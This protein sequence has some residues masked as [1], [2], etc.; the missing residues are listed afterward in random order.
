MNR[1][2]E[3]PATTPRVSFTRIQPPAESCTSAG[4][5]VISCACRA[6]LAAPASPA[7]PPEWTLGRA[8]PCQVG[9]RRALQA[10]AAAVASV[11]S[12]A[13]TM[14]A[15]M[16]SGRASQPTWGPMRPLRRMRS[17]ACA[18][19]AASQ[20]GTSC[21]GSATR[22]A[23]SPSRMRW[24]RSRPKARCVNW[25]RVEAASRARTA[26]SRSVDS[27]AT[28]AGPACRTRSEQT[29][30]VITVPMAIRSWRMKPAHITT[31]LAHSVSKAS[32]KFAGTLHCRSIAVN[33]PSAPVPLTTRSYASSR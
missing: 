25:A 30:S 18:R 22:P 28:M 4:G 33:A 16:P 13:L 19:A 17:T 24:T 29:S 14:T 6:A 11:A 9:M 8:P 23:R 10:A 5:R 26:S 7:V 20:A 31:T 2:R 32:D 12:G 15:W 3:P 1:E 27:R 21:A